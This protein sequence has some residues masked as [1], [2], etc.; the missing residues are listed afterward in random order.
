MEEDFPSKMTEKDKIPKKIA[1]SGRSKTKAPKKNR[2][3]PQKPLLRN[4]I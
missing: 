3:P 2:K 1:V 4:A